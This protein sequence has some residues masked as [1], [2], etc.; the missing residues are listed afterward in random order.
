MNLLKMCSP[1]IRLCLFMSQTI[2]LQLNSLTTMN[3]I[4]W[5]GGPEVTHPTGVREVL[6]SIPGSGNIF[7][8]AFLFCCFVVVFLLFCP[9][10]I[11][12]PEIL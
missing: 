12:F 5:L 10:H 4:S 8:F 7:I 1:Q 9:K 6:G 2:A 11:I 3:T